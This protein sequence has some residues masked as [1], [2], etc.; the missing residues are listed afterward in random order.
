MPK[1][2]ENII[3]FDIRRFLMTCNCVAEMVWSS[4]T[5]GFG[6]GRA[7]SAIGNPKPGGGRRAGCGGRCGG[8]G[9]GRALGGDACAPA[10]R[11]SV[12]LPAAASLDTRHRARARPFTR[13]A[14]PRRANTWP[15]RLYMTK[16]LKSVLP[17]ATTV[18]PIHKN[19]TTTIRVSIIQ[20]DEWSMAI[21]KKFM[22]QS[23]IKLECDAHRQL[24]VLRAPGGAAEALPSRLKTTNRSIDLLHSRE[25]IHTD[26]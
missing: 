19:P 18:L 16:V 24:Q 11:R 10:P 3:F 26:R 23:F 14:G 7:G 1:N 22:L 8:V 6:G 21:W 17:I 25:M 4:D 20:P 13:A 2:L 9:A 12:T 15:P 5:A